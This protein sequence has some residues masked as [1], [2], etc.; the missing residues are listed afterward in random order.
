MAE[1][2]RWS[3]EELR[4]RLSGP[5]PDVAPDLLGWRISHSNSEGTVT[6]ELTEV[7]AYAGRAD[8]ASHA[9]HGSTNRNKVM[10]GSAGKLYVYFSYGVHWCANI[11]AGVE[12]EASAVLLR[13][14]RVVAGVELARERRGSKVADRALARGP[15]CLTQALGISAAHDGV[16]LVIDA[17]LRLQPPISGFSTL[18]TTSD[19]ARVASGP[20]VG[21]SRAADVSWRFWLR[22]DETVSSYKRSN[23]APRP[24]K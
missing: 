6:V 24:T 12:G 7:E 14:G 8:P 9:F 10:F 2:V 17:R 1:T 4:A 18:H 3:P 5:G 19:D 23:R 21:V 11:V 15:A 13:A 22:G 20:R 16:D